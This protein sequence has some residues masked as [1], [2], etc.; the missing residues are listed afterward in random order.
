MINR[1]APLLLGIGRGLLEDNVTDVHSVVGIVHERHADR[2]SGGRS[3][4]NCGTDGRRVVL[5]APLLKCRQGYHQV[6]TR[7][8][9]VI[10]EP[11]S[12]AGYPI[13]NPGEHSGV[14][15]AAPQP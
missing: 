14:N 1:S 8:R 15:E 10:A 2:F 4:D 11:G 6:L 3:A 7:R 5:V 12:R 13:G 9:S